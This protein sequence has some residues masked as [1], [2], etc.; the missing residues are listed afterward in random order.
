MTKERI[1]GPFRFEPQSGQLWNQDLEVR[2][3]PKAA[4]VLAMLLERA[5]QPV[6][7]QALFTSIWRDTV[8]SD[9]ALVSC[10]QELR[11]ALADDARRPQYIETRHRMGYRFI[12]A[13]AP[14]VEQA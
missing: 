5:G 2:L 3:T 1:F 13:L 12:A 11:H 9:D 6:S 4:A 7:K 14:S 8:V 10:I